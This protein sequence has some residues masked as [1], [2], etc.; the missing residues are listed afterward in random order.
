MYIQNIN[1]LIWQKPTNLMIKKQSLT[2]KNDMKHLNE[3]PPKVKEN[4]SSS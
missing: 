3:N 2:Y 1:Q 4:A